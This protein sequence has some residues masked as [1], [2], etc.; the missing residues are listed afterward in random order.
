LFFSS[1]FASQFGSACF[2]DKLTLL[3]GISSSNILIFTLWPIP[4]ASS[5]ESILS[6]EISD[7]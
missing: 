7:T 5:G 6:T 4:R 2:I 1:S 3:L